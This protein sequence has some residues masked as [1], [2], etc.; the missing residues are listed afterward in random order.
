MG[1]FR[2]RKFLPQKISSFKVLDNSD[3][4]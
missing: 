1:E 4:H 3:Y 2:G